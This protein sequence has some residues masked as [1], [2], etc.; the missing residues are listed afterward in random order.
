MLEADTLIQHYLEGT[1]TAAEAEQLHDLLKARPGRMNGRSGL[2]SQHDVLPHWLWV[3]K[4]RS[5]RT[6]E[7]NIRSAASVSQLKCQIQISDSPQPN[8]SNPISA[9]SKQN[10]IKSPRENDRS[11][12]FQSSNVS[13]P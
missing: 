1:L 13:G 7:S 10:S 2:Q 8:A 3:V 12:R 5:R 11:R 6:R 9:A 4:S